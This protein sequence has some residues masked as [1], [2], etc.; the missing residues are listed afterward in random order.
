MVTSR[1]P[2]FTIGELDPLMRSRNDI[3][4]YYS[5]LD[6]ARNV[7]ILTQG[8][9]KRRPGSVYVDRAHRQVQR[10][11]GGALVITAPNGGNITNINDND[12]T[13]FLTTTTN[14]GTINPYVVVQYDLGAGTDVAFID[15]VNASLSTGADPTEFFIQASNDNITWT[16]LGLVVPMS[17]TPITQRNRIRGNYRYFRFVRIGATNLG[18]ATVSI[19]E[20]SVWQELA[21][22]SNCKLIPY[23]FNISQSYMFLMT[24][25][26]I[27]VYKN[28]VF[29]TDVSA[30]S[31]PNAII[32]T[33]NFTSAGD[34]IILLQETVT[35][36]RIFRQGSDVSWGVDP[37]DFEYIP[38]YDFNLVE[39]NPAATITPNAVTGS[40]TI[41]ASA[42]VF[43][44]ANVNQFI[45]GNGGRAR[46]VSFT[47]TT[48]VQAV[49]EIPFYTTNT[50]AVGSWTLETGWEPVWSPTRGYPRCGAFFQ[51]RLWFGG[52]TGRPRTLWASVLGDYFNFDPGAFRDTDAL[53]VDVDNEEP[54]VNLLANKTLQ[55]FSEGGESAII[56]QIRGLTTVTPSNP[57]II[58][59]TDE[60]S[61]PYLRPLAI[62]GA[63]LFVKRGADSISQLIYNELENTFSTSSV[64]LFSGHLITTVVDFAYR[65]N[66]PDTESSWLLIVNDNGTLVMSSLE[67]EQDVKGFSLWSTA[68][69]LYKNVGVDID[70]VYTV[71]Q[72]TINGVATNYLEVFDFNYFT[73]AAVH[74]TTGLPTNTF[75]N[76]DFLDGQ[77]VS[78]IA[79]GN[80]LPSQTVANG[81]IITPRNVVTQV[82]FGID[83]TP[84]ILVRTL[85]YENPQVV[86]EI[87][88]TNKRVIECILRLYDT[89]EIFVNGT[90]VSMKFFGQAGTGP[91]DE[92]NPLFT[93]EKRIRANLGWDPFGQVSFTQRNPLPMTVL[94]VGL[95]MDV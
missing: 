57:G 5:A 61:A 31:Y 18:A 84:L 40:V 71:V 11:V 94:A 50:I 35:P 22:L 51:Q 46:I 36:N 75:N 48:V 92:P 54:F 17:T 41:T 8:G 9:F 15:V 16:S 10:V 19:A 1:Q 90:P 32:P 4:F 60:G 55:I 74:V 42:A 70:D 12:P 64:S 49:M 95:K 67:A 72:R 59:Q 80:I 63:S 73:D 2:R 62:G 29:Q 43:N 68:N 65:K 7:I 79:D 69:G 87:I 88:G 44:L 6:K 78:I 66:N 24:D 13:T 83:F 37:I 26:N 56:T 77:L 58:P 20:F 28:R 30:T 82:E 39:T 3:E 81:Q 76:L 93:G 45:E 14:V 91:L 34:T 52:S 89:A 23:K 85:P 21:T 25:T 47:S 27:A 33:I 38:F 86:G 53:D